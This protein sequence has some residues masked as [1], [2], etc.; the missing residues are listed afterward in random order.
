MRGRHSKLTAVLLIFAAWGMGTTVGDAVAAHGAARLCVLSD[1]AAVA[2]G[3]LFFPGMI[4][5]LFRWGAFNGLLY[6]LRYAGSALL[7]GRWRKMP[8]Y[9]DCASTGR[10]NPDGSEQ[11]LLAFGGALLLLSAMFAVLYCRVS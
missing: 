5:C 6:G 1:G 10:N 3:I 8:P 11:F 2:G 7:P 4:S 9:G